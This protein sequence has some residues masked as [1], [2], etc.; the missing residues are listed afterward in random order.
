MS[1]SAA[2][3][4]KIAIILKQKILRKM[5]VIC[6]KVQKSMFIITADCTT[7]LLSGHREFK[8]HFHFPWNICADLLLQNAQ[9]GCFI[10][11]DTAHRLRL[12]QSCAKRCLYMKQNIVALQALSWK[13]KTSCWML[14]MRNFKG[15][16][17]SASSEK[18]QAIFKASSGYLPQK[19]RLLK[20]LLTPS[21]W[22]PW[23]YWMNILFSSNVIGN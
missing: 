4:W 12:I 21:A 10:H 17:L 23:M 20:S 14:S 5:R 8:Y 2:E 11:G 9:E 19:Q 1:I 3:M 7:K 18:L 22:S 16:W 13:G 6:V 15:G